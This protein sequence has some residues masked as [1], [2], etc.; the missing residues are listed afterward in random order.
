[1]NG[2]SGSHKVAV[3]VLPVFSSD[4]TL[5]VLAAIGLRT[6]PTCCLLTGSCLSSLSHEPHNTAPH[7][8]KVNYR[9]SRMSEVKVAQL[10]LTLCNPIDYTVHG[11]SR[12]EYRSGEPFPSPGDL[13]NPGIK[14]RSPALQ[15]YSLLNELSEKPL[16]NENALPK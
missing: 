16:Q 12:P 13:P 15:A 14:P 8:F 10:C 3:R 1:M 5:R 4:G 6:L 9:V 11:F 7:F 2:L